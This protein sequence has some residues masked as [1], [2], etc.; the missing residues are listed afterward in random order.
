MTRHLLKVFEKCSRTLKLT[1][2]DIEILNEQIISNRASLHLFEG[3]RALTTGGANAALVHFQE[4][5]EHLRSPK[6]KL[7]IVLLR[8]MPR[9]VI[10]VFT[11]R[12]RWQ[13]SQ[14]DNELTGIDQPRE[15]SSSETVVG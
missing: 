6:L 9:A 12:E 3:K 5:N 2:S 10:W 8:H 4:A 14:A 7:V 13:S 1:P 11:E 15:T